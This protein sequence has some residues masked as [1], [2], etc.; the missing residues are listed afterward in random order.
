MF[1]SVTCRK[2][3]YWLINQSPFM[4][5]ADS[6]PCSKPATIGLYADS[7]EP[8]PH[9]RILCISE[10]VCYCPTSCGCVPWVRFITTIHVNYL[11][12]PLI[13]PF[14]MIFLFS[15]S[16]LLSYFLICCLLHF[17]IFFFQT[18]SF[19]HCSF[20]SVF[21]SFVRS[22]HIPFIGLRMGCARRVQAHPSVS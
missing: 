11:I 14:L 9:P 16:L 6:L 20:L 2:L 15:N 21:I 7:D 4:E 8:T 3:K 13:L 10:A 12:Y 5:P 18:F 1:V 19:F 22:N 17:C